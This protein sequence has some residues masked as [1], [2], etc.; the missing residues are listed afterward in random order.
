M[1]KLKKPAKTEETH[2][3]SEDTL[4]SI[5]FDDEE[6][7]PTALR[8]KS[9]KDVMA[10]INKKF[11]ERTLYT[12]GQK[13]DLPRLPTGVHAVDYIIGGGF[14]VTQS[15]GLH[16]GY[17]GGKTTLALNTIAVA[18][19]LC[20]RCYRPEKYCVCSEKALLK[21]AAVA[22]VEGTL[23]KLW[24]RKIGVN[25]DDL[26]VIEASG[27]EEYIDITY[28]VLQ[29]EE[30]GFCLFDSVGAAISK[31]E[32]ENAADASNM[33]KAANIITKLAKKFKQAL[34]NE[35]KAGH[36]LTMLYINQ[37]RMNLKQM[38]GNPESIGGGEAIKHEQ[39]LLLRCGNLS[40]QDKEKQY[41]AKDKSGER[42]TATKHN[43]S[44]TRTK[45]YT[46]G[47]KAEYL[48][49][50][51]YIHPDLGRLDGKPIDY[52]F[53]VAQARE[54]GILGDDPKKYVFMDREYKTLLELTRQLHSD[55]QDKLFM[56]MMIVEKA[57]AD[58]L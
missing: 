23:D 7:P 28:E 6:M 29:A 57:K 8:G 2:E 48:R 37:K 58:R 50:V 19:V 34:I 31:A 18:Q 32:L 12:L 47:A 45:V 33:G 55:F 40:L 17:S 15:S 11:G 22:N 24:A 38:F 9:L 10:L 56:S 39:S 36:Q 35:N 42:D 26:I 41:K 13:P 14:P 51:D 5:D 3:D 53:L 4:T 21:T 46:L 1:K 25:V 27:I 43:V 54:A 49:S 20:M 52:K 44:V 30:I 16:G